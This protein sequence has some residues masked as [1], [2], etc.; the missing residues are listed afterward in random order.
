MI[1]EKKAKAIFQMIL[2]DVKIGYKKIS[3]AIDEVILLDKHTV[4]EGNFSDWMDRVGEYTTRFLS[5]VDL[6]HLFD[7]EKREIISIVIRNFPFFSAKNIYKIGLILG[8]IS[9]KPE[10]IYELAGRY[11]IKKDREGEYIY[12]VYSTYPALPPIDT[13]INVLI[14]KDK[15]GKW[16][17]KFLIDF[18]DLVSSYKSRIIDAILQKGKNTRQYYYVLELAQN[19]T[20]LESADIDKIIRFMKMYP[21]GNGAWLVKLIIQKPEWFTPTEIIEIQRNIVKDPIAMYELAKKVKDAD[22]EFAKK[23]IKKRMPIEAYLN[24]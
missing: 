8:D 15:T 17:S 21:V 23:F 9:D 20:I 5:S 6:K 14:E 4:V 2:N 3:T 24:L 16:L 12:L 18:P 19:C 11:I 13:T 7:V 10:E 1:E 22:K